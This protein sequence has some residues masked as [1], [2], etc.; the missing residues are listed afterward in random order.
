MALYEEN[1]VTDDQLNAV[2]IDVRKPLSGKCKFCPRGF[3]P[4][5]KIVFVTMKS[6][7]MKW[8]DEDIEHAEPAGFGEQHLIDVINAHLECARTFSSQLRG[9][10][11][12]KNLI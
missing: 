2:A 7:Q 5:E 4:G 1:N 10:V 12:P 11:A 8:M 9:V 3:E 6:I